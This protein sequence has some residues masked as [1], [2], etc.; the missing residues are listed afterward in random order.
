MGEGDTTNCDGSKRKTE[1]STVYFHVNFVTS[2]FHNIK[3][4]LFFH[5]QSEFAGL[6]SKLLVNQRRL[7]APYPQ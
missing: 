7:G 6:W 4:V 3:A 1:L 5:L 2:D